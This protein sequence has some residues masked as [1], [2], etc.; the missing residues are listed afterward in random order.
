MAASSGSADT[1]NNEKPT[2]TF[3]QFVLRFVVGAMFLALLVMVIEFGQVRGRV[4]QLET[5]GHPPWRP[6]RTRWARPRRSRS[7]SRRC[8]SSPRSSRSQ[9]APQ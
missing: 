7:C 5:G 4:H 2:F 6:P 8:R 3:E 1:G 9:P